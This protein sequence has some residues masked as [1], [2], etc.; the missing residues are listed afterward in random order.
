MPVIHV[1]GGLPLAAF[2]VAGQR[3]R[4][5]SGD[6]EARLTDYQ[7]PQENAPEPALEISGAEDR[8]GNSLFV[9]CSEYHN[10]IEWNNFPDGGGRL[11]EKVSD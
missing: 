8:T 7:F 10:D 6:Y 4:V 11:F 9:K 2:N 3:L 5:V 1:I